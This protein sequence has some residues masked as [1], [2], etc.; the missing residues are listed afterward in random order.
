MLIAFV[1]V[2]GSCNKTDDSILSATDSQNLSSEEVSESFTDE[3]NDVSNVAV[4]GITEVEYAGSRTEGELSNSL[5]DLD[6]RLKCATVT[7]TRTPNSTKDNPS[8]SILIDFGAGCTDARGVVRKGKIRVA[9]TGKRFF[10][11]ST[12]TTTF[13][14]YFRNEVKVEGTHTLTNAQATLLSNPKFTV[15]IVGGKITFGDGKTVTREQ[16]FTREWLRATSPNADKW[17]ILKGSAASG[18]NRNDKT[19]TMEVT[20]DLEYSR[21]CAVSNKVFIAVKGTKVF[22]T[23]SKIFTV[24]YGTGACDNDITVTV[25]G[26]TKTI[27]VG[28]NGN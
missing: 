24:D 22:T 8:G 6:D 28:A 7:I 12:I 10:P 26:A 18:K 23:D 21:A 3:A 17:V 13:E 15:R 2:L 25:N 20:A 19:Y 9:F 11:G 1:L 16:S 4:N 27:T 14:D 5:K